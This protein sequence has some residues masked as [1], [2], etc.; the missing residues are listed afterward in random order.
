MYRNRHK[1]C[2]IEFGHKQSITS[3]LNCTKSTLF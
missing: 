3:D 2:T 1:L